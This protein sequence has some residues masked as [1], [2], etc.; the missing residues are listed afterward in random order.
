MKLIEICSF[1][2]RFLRNFSDKQEMI[3]RPISLDERKGP[4]LTLI[5]EEQKDEFCC[6]IKSLQRESQLPIRSKLRSLNPFI[7][8]GEI[9]QVVR[10]HEQFRVSYNCKY[11]IIFAS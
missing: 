3:S 6:D 5:R 9:L 1:I 11:P 2:F 7:F 4:E 10:R 8:N